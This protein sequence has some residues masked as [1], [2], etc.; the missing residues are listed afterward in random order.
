M[1]STSAPSRPESAGGGLGPGSV[2]GGRFAIERAVSEDALGTLLAAKDQKTSRPIAVRVLAP[3]LIATPEA[4]ETLRAEVKTAAAIQHK[5]LVATYGMGNDKGGARFVATE[6]VDGQTLADVIRERKAS[7]EP[8]SLRGAYNVVAHVCRG[9]EA[10]EKSGAAHGALRPSVVWVTKAGRVKVASLGLDRALVKAAGPA[11]LGASEQAYLAPEVKAGGEAD[12]RSDVFGIG[13]LLYGMLTGRSAA[14]DFIAPSDAHPEASPEVDAV[15][16]KCLALDPAARFATPGEVKDA[17][18]SLAGGTKPA[19]DQH[20]FGVDVDVD[21]EIGQSVPPPPVTGTRPAMP[22]P[23]APPPAKAK[24]A[25]PPAAPQVGARVAVDQSFRPHEMTAPPALS[26]EV[27]LGGLLSK[28]TENDAARWMVVKDNLDHGP[29]SGRELV[30]LLLKGE[31]LA[32]HGLLNLDTGQR[33]KIKEAPE[34]AEFADQFKM[35]KAAADHQVALA[36]SATREKRGFVAKGAIL[37]AVV[38]AVGLGVGIFFLT[39]PEAT[40][41]EL[42]EARLTDLYERGEIEITGSAG[43]LEDPAPTGR[44]GRRR[45]GGGARGG[46]S[47]EDAMN[48]VV[49]LGNVQQ[50]G[51]MSRLSPQQVAGVM[52]QNINR[53]LPCVAREP[54]VGTVRIEMAIAGSGQVLGA[55]VRNGSPAF[56]SCVSGRVRAIRFPS[57]GAPRMGASFTF[58]AD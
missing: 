25:G 58:S 9:L 53:L 13:G 18:V 30:Q 56:Q 17:L 19:E 23:P 45:G 27:D 11:V 29:F 32:D 41:E 31:V 44:R 46:L 57:F 3:G 12:A 42:A 35:K 40:E 49:D 21:V 50:G 1:S 26:A 39:R 6:W 10:A 20:D 5:N 38:A 16:L 4:V 22:K 34:F 33:R 28:I 52:N 14:D 43:L 2:V 37:A 54:G 15:L 51:S 36:K 55:S 24:P 8:L 48:E 7:G 47:Y